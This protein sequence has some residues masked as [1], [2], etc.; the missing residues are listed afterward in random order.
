M[1]SAV[2]H[3]T[4]VEDILHRLVNTPCFLCT[5]CTH[6]KCGERKE[7]W[8]IYLDVSQVHVC[9]LLHRGALESAFLDLIGTAQSLANH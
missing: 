4:V 7:S 5:L 3:F 9:A 2:S 8:R 1:H 6:I